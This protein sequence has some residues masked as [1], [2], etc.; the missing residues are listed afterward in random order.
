MKEKNRLGG[1]I[2]IFEMREEDSTEID[3]EFELA[4]CEARLQ[5]QM[6]KQS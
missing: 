5:E 4:L 6:A 2:V 3:D 1:K